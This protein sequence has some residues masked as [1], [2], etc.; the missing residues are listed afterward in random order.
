MPRPQTCNHAGFQFSQSLILRCGKC[1]APLFLPPACLVKPLP[2]IERMFGIWCRA[3]WPPYD[4]LRARWLE[5]PGWRRLTHPLF[6]D[7]GGIQVQAGR[8][9]DFI[10]AYPEWQWDC[11]QNLHAFLPALRAWVA[12]FS[13]LDLAADRLG[14]AP[15]ALHDLLAEA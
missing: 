8:V 3:G 13:V 9:A 6:C 12:N 7:L 14:L 15:E 5:Q 2:M 4:V 10:A 11:S 1:S